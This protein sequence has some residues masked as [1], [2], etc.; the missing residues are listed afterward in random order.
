MDD[1]LHSIL[2]R[3]RLQESFA[4]QFG[5]PIPMDAGLGRRISCSRHPLLWQPM[6][7][8]QSSTTCERYK[9]A[10]KPSNNRNS[11]FSA[12]ATLFSSSNPNSPFIS[13]LIF[14][15]FNRS[16]TGTP[17]AANAMPACY[18]C[19]KLATYTLTTCAL[20]TGKSYAPPFVSLR[21]ISSSEMRYDKFVKRVLKTVEG[22]ET[23][24]WSQS[25][26][27]KPT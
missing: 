26:E 16:A 22:M 1:N 5:S 3:C 21:R 25:C 6:A 8:S 10:S 11:T 27:R 24:K 4:D 17:T 12:S 18:T 14:K 13:S 15:L 9:N 2:L 23:P 19:S 20:S 7:T